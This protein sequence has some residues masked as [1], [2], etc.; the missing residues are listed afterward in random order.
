MDNITHSL[1]KLGWV[2]IKFGVRPVQTLMIGLF[3][4]IPMFPQKRR[5]K[6]NKK[7]I[8]M[9]TTTEGLGVWDL[10]LKLQSGHEEIADE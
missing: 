6:W 10:P 3:R 8:E 1:H 5:I 4:E 2:L 7:S 9:G